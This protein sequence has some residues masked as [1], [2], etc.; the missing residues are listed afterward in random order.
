MRDPAGGEERR[1]GVERVGGVDS[2]AGEEVAG[3][4]ESHEDHEQAAE[5]IDCFDARETRDGGCD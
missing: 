3:V 2:R 4:V 1:P 5:E